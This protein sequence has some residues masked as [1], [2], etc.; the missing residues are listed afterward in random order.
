MS[1][2]PLAETAGRLKHGISTILILNN[3]YGPLHKRNDSE[4]QLDEN[5]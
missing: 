1:S 2:E 3:L 5:K 4:G